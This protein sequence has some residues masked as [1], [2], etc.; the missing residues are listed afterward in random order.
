MGESLNGVYT[1]SNIRTENEKVARGN[2]PIR[3]RGKMEKLCLIIL[4][5]ERFFLFVT[6]G[7]VFGNVFSNQKFIFGQL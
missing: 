4:I 5:L 7:C 3:N 1:R 6:G 2:V